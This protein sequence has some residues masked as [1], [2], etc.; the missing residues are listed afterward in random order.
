M[1]YGL[2]HMTSAA[3]QY[4]AIAYQLNDGLTLE[5]QLVSITEKLPPLTEEII[6]ELQPTIIQQQLSQPY[7]A[8]AITAVID[9]AAQHTNNLVHKAL[10]AWQLAQAADHWV[11]PHRK[12]EAIMRARQHYQ[13]LHQIQHLAACN[14][15]EYAQPWLHADI[16]KV[17]H[18]LEASC[19]TLVQGND[20]TWLP[21]AYLSLAN[22]YTLKGSYALSKQYTEKSEALFKIRDD[23]LN[24]ARCWF[25]HVRR[26]RRQDGF[27]N[28]IPYLERA[29]PI[30]EKYDA[31][32]DTAKI[33]IVFG[34]Y[35]WFYAS[36]REAAETHF[37]QA[38]NL[39]R[40]C[41]TPL[42]LAYCYN[43]LAELYTNNGHFYKA[44]QHLEQ[45]KHIYDQANLITGAYIDNILDY[46]HLFLRIGNYAASLNHFKQAITLYQKVTMPWGEAT[47]HM[48]TGDA[49]LQMGIYQQALHYYEQAI[50]YFQKLNSPH[51][52]GQCQLRLAKIQIQLGQLEKASLLL[53]EAAHNL[54]KS[55]QNALLIDI[56]NT[57]AQLLFEQKQHQPA[58]HVLKKALATAKQQA[59]E[60]HIAL[61]TRMLGAAS[62]AA[63][64]TKQAES[65]LLEA[66]KLFAQ[67]GMN[68]EQSCCQE[69]L[70]NYY[71]QKDQLDKAQQYWTQTLALNEGLASETTWQAEVGLAKI[72]LRQQNKQQALQQYK[73]AV[74][75][76][77]QL[78]Q[79]FWQPSLVG[80]YLHK[81]IDVWHE[82]VLLAQ[83]TQNLDLLL[84]FI[85]VNKAQTFLRQLLNKSPTVWLEHHPQLVD[86]R[87]E[88][89]D[90]QMK[91]R[92]DFASP[93]IATSAKRAQLRQHLKQKRHLYAEMFRQIARQQNV[94]D[95]SSPTPFKTEQFHQLANQHLGHKWIALNYYLT[96]DDLI[97]LIITPSG[98]E[99]I[100]YRLS[101]KEKRELTWTTTKK[102][103][104]LLPNNIWQKLGT[105]LIPPQIQS[106]LTPETYLLLI[107]HAL[108]HHIPWAHLQITNAAQPLVNYCVPTVVP[109]LHSLTLM[110]QRKSHKS[111]PPLRGVIIGVSHFVHGYAQLPRIVNEVKAI[112]PYLDDKSRI[113]LDSQ[114]IKANLL[115]QYTEGLDYYDILHIA[116]HAFP[117]SDP[118]TGRLSGFALWDED[119]WLDDL[120]DLAPLP[121]LVVLSA[122]SGT[123]GRVYDG[124]EHL[125]LTTT[126]LAAGADC[127]IGALQAVPDKTAAHLMAHFYKHLSQNKTPAMSLALA[128][129]EIIAGEANYV[130]WQ[131]FSCVGLPAF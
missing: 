101:P 26:I 54:Q 109:S 93:T 87:A 90:I 29:Q 79:D 43:A 61:I 44:K 19:D 52:I 128:Q 42:W 13:Q 37:N 84:Q 130:G 53:D 94:T 7:L 131:E 122:C 99:T 1:Y 80:S 34:L 38:Q 75:I 104:N 83:E 14:W 118:Q 2:N 108:L 4:L 88:I 20:Q 15:L 17:V 12:Q 24:Q 69:I 46:G 100:K 36:N 31:K 3:Q 55:Q 65:Y 57:R 112:A 23:T 11:R 10:A 82:A 35:D 41:N 64:N 16:E 40:R 103:Q 129:R 78:R 67:L 106:A 49:C 105:L 73:K 71:W 5:P 27:K 85:E 116:T 48:N 120:W 9:K 72:A 18:Q 76:I 127:V 111:L 39:F 89:A 62:L 68:L 30:F 56:N 102:K 60:P 97:C 51:R 22:A 113:I 32:I 107:P 98:Q 66:D 121:S 115:E 124:D 74:N 96:N 45:A 81:R 58:I 92:V 50:S 125:G 6:N 33:Y 119:L 123:M 117:D 59:R 86:L 70:G 77:S 91:L 25:A 28:I 126:C 8:W 21:H 63:N 95:V 110:W 114:A 47:A